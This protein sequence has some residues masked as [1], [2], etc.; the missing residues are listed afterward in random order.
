MSQEPV[1]GLS[2]TSYQTLFCFRYAN[3]FWLFLAEITK[4]TDYDRPLDYTIELLASWKNYNKSRSM[5]KLDVVKFGWHVYSVY[6]D[7]RTHWRI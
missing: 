1:H 2:K 7:D 3:T 6:R 4:V 5:I